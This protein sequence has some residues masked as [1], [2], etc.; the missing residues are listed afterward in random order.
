[1]KDCGTIGSGA[2][3]VKGCSLAYSHREYPGTHTLSSGRVELLYTLRCLSSIRLAGWTGKVHHRLDNEG[4]VKRCQHISSGFRTAASADA[5]LWTAMC[6]YLDE[7]RDE[8]TISW[9]KSHAEEGGAKT[10]EHEVQNKKADEDA[11]KAYAHT[12]S[13]GYEQVY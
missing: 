10:T 7:W 9:V 11:E 8:T 13:A 12:D 6:S 3:H 2:W 1:M 5:D 4:V